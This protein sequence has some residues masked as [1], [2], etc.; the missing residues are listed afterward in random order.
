MS[1]PATKVL[2][3]DDDPA[4]LRLLAKWL[5]GAGYD[6]IRATDGREAIAILERDPP[7]V[8]VTDCEMPDVGGLELCRWLRGQSFPHYI[9]TIFLTVRSESSDIVKG[10]EAGADDFLKK[11]VD[12][13]EL[14]ARMQAATRVTELQRQLS[15][16]ASTDAVTGVY[17]RR[18][19]HDFLHREWARSKRH[20]HPLACVMLDLDYFKK[21]NDT[22]GHQV[23]DEVL[24]EV[25]TLLK[26]HTRA[27]DVIGR[28]GGEEFCVLLTESTEEQ[29]RT[30]TERVLD[31]LQRLEIPTPQGPLQV[32]ASCGL[33]ERMVDT[34]S[35]EQLVDMAD[36]ALLV[37][38]RSGRDRAVTYRSITQSIMSP[39]T[40]GDP[41]RI[42]ANVP[43]CAVM[44]SRV[45][46]LSEN[47]TVA[48]ASSYFLRFR[49]HSAPV[50]DEQGL[51]VGILSEK[52]V[53]A[54][55][56]GQHWWSTHI[57]DLMKRNVVCYEEDSPA[58]AIYEFL[59]RVTIRGVVVVKEGRPTGLITRGSLLR[60]FLNEAAVRREEL[61]K[62]ELESDSPR[63]NYDLPEFPR[64]RL[65]MATAA[66]MKET[67]ELD[68][69]I[70][71]CT[72]D[73]VP[74]VV[75]AASR[76]QELVLDLLAMTRTANDVYT[77]AMA[78][79]VAAPD[80]AGQQPP[81]AAQ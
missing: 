17:S 23:G 37:A 35:P 43:A 75:A 6:V 69:Q 76:I 70:D 63:T 38:K 12:R 32:T 53:M 81:A 47:D 31:E 4:M 33:A 24:R 56:L 78:F 41:A 65:A 27:S 61:L 15:L 9:Y 72:D 73:V 1:A 13:E 48:A 14:L 36:Q 45:A 74:C 7:S 10:L 11:P 42:L 30:W 54:I 22:H 28:Y 80:G 71:R 2:L 51:L 60:Y 44:T 59:C 19:W 34:V 46:P 18:S 62:L 8:L 66:L 21:I 3:V 57:K 20:Q 50:V 25:G 58:L 16:Q 68:A 52:D 40:E 67:A 29:A 64:Q 26:R 55:K 77:G 5:E 49:I 39:L 79:S